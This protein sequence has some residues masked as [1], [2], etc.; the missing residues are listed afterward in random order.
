M[1]FYQDFSENISHSGF[2]MNY[3][4]LSTAEIKPHKA[5]STKSSN[6]QSGSANGV[7]VDLGKKYIYIKNLSS[8]YEFMFKI[9]E[10]HC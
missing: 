1:I 4:G 6:L 7:Y 10:K 3:L 8:S 2:K 5:N 9:Q